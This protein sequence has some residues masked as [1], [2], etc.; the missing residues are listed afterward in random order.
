MIRKCFSTEA[1]HIALLTIMITLLGGCT[2]SGREKAMMTTTPP[3]Q[4]SVSSVKTFWPQ[5]MA[6]AQEW[7]SDAFVLEAE[8]GIRFL[9]SPT[10]GSSANFTFQS[11]SEDYK[12]FVVSCSTEKCNSFEVEHEKGYPVH[13]CKPFF[14]EDF[15]LDSQEALDIALQNGGA[16]YINLQSVIAD[17]SLSRGFPLCTDTVI[18]IASF[19]DLANFGINIG[20]DANTGEVIELPG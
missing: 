14:P 10:K 6:I 19:M 2:H 11:P 3:S 20:I 13:H 16:D 15:K 18:W 1:M 7:R 8:V 9:K 4:I 12:V 17:L 5:A